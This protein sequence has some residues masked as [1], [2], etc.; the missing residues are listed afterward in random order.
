MSVK[1]ISLN[2]DEEL[3]NQINECA[4]ELGIDLGEL[5]ELWIIKGLS[6]FNMVNDNC[7]LKDLANTITLPYVT[8][9]VEITDKIRYQI[10]NS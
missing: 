2:L 3:I 5:I 8:D 4:S 1:E 6:Q 7:S 10:G 9:S